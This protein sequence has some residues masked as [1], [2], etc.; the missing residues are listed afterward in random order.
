[1]NKLV[2]MHEDVTG[3]VKLGLPML[4]S[5]RNYIVVEFN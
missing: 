4:S 2:I 3:M 5:S 1:M